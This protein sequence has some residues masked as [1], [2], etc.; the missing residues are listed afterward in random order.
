MNPLS[1]L[2]LLVFLSVSAVHA[3]TSDSIV[4]EGV[5][6]APVTAVWNTWS[7]TA[8]LKSWLA[9]HADID[10]RIDGIMR[11]NYNPMLLCYS[12]R[13]VS[14]YWFLSGIFVAA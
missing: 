4:T 8:G 5:I 14:A 7:T 1:T 10:L 9:P 6:S 12:V 13:L 3:Q 11:A 2:T